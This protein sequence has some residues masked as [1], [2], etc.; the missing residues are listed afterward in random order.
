MPGELLVVAAVALVV[1]AW[2]W[3]TVRRGRA[4]RHLDDQLSARTE[5]DR[6]TALERI[7]EDGLAPHAAAVLSLAHREASPAVQAAIVDLVARHQWEPVANPAMANL[8]L[9]AAAAAP[10]LRHLTTVDAGP[11]PGSMEAEVPLVEQ[12]ERALGEPVA[13]M[14]LDGADGTFSVHRA[15]PAP[16][17]VGSPG[18]VPGS[19]SDP[20]G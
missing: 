2:W 5:T 4:E 8:R 16:P 3:R 15:D 11:V 6:L 18:A 14:S 9:W 12:V 1:A 10:G 7:G 19:G 17:D 13:W 20:W